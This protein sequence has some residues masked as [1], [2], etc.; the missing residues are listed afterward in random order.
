MSLIFTALRETI[1]ISK[2][3]SKVYERS[4]SQMYRDELKILL[5]NHNYLDR[6]CTI[7]RCCTFRSHR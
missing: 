7:L 5:R 4:Q 6:Y 3:L 1:Q 2:V